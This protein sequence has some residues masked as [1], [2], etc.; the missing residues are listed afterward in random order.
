MPFLA[1]FGV[2]VET[3][4]FVIAAFFLLSVLLMFTFVR[5]LYDSVTAGWACML[6]ATLPYMAE[7]GQSVLSEMTA[8]ACVLAAMNALMRFRRTGRVRDYLLL[9]VLAVVSLAARQ[10]AVFMFPAYAL[11][12]LRDNGWRQFRQPKILIPTVI[13]IGLLGI[14]V[15]ATLILSPFNVEAIR[16]VLA[17]TSGHATTAGLMAII[18][19]EQLHPALFVLTL[20]G[21]AWALLDGDRRALVP[22]AWMLS[23][24]L[25]VIFVTGPLEP[26][27][28]SILAVPAY[29][30]AGASLWARARSRTAMA[31]VTSAIA[32]AS[33]WQAVGALA[34][35]PVGAHGYEEAA[36]YVVEH[37]QAPTV[38]YTGVVDTGY[39]VFFVRK[40][41]AERRFVVLRSDKILTTSRMGHLSVEDRI[42]D[43][44]Q[45]YDTLRQFGTRY[46]VI[47]DIASGTTVIDWLRD[48]LRTAHFAERQRFPIDTRDRRLRGADVVVYEY[49][50]ATPPARD[51]EI[52]VKLPI[53][54]REIRLPLSDFLRLPAGSSQP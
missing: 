6:F 27:R 31:I 38:L 43:R 20:A 25:G 29:C 33:A 8:I 5:Q 50:E 2:S 37:N 24:M 41:D 42:T 22:I 23:V 30:L 39:F 14:V 35:R 49:L 45:I 36:R 48:E 13:G 53:V 17:G 16:R 1:V 4:R 32:A 44:P 3:A 10:L 40:H 19:R 15:V 52:D 46:V 47:E 54:G 51:A 34:V 11:L 9:V 18:V 28:Y 12:L 21:I 26:A 7:F